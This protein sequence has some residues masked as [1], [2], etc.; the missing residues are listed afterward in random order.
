MPKITLIDDEHGPMDF[1]VIALRKSGFEVEHLDNVAD[2]LKHIAETPTPSD[3]YI[4]DLMM[5]VGESGLNLERAKYGLASGIEIHRQLRQRFA[6]VPVM[7]LTSVSNPTIIG[8]IPFDDRTTC[9][10]KIEVLPFELVDKVRELL[11]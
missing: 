3:F 6:T 5:P 9:E 1:Y 11:A 10:A 8:A 2:A 4:I 7:I